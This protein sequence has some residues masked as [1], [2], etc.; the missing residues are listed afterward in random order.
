MN[1]YSPKEWGAQVDYDTWDDAPKDED[2]IIVHYGGNASFA[3]DEARTL[4]RGYDEWP[5]IAAE[6]AVLRIYE[7]SHLSRGWRGL[8]Y[9]WAIGQSGNVYRIR[10][11]NRYGAHKG[12]LDLDGIPENEEGIPILF[13]IGGDQVPTKEA[14]ATFAALHTELEMAEGP[15]EVYGH[16]EIALLG[17]GTT[18]SCPGV[19]LTGFVKAWRAGEVKTEEPIK[20]EGMTLFPIVYGDGTAEGRPEKVED[21]AWLQQTLKAL[22]FGW[23]TDAYGQYGDGTAKALSLFMGK[24]DGKA[25]WGYEGFVLMHALAQKASR[26]GGISVSEADDRYIRKGEGVKLIG[27]IDSVA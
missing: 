9:G 19:H 1:V 2:K 5:S 17:T 10:G 24:G 15:L 3:G 23:G 4:A 26:G 6:M 8:A 11:W 18:T 20:Q 7:Q 21:V 25:V 13:L 27:P 22:G 16:K 12:D 14:L